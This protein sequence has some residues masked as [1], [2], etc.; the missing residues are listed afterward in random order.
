MES[1]LL[2]LKRYAQFDG[3]SSR[4][5]YWMFHLLQTVILIV[6]IG[7]SVAADFA[8]IAVV[9][10]VIGVLFFGVILACF[11]PNLAVTIRRLHDTDKSG[12]FLLVGA[13][14]LVG[15]IVMLVFLVL[16]GSP[17]ENRFGPQPV[18]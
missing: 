8:Y 4:R 15:G 10:T 13:I 9:P 17:G 5:E 3:R 1:M 18:I 11:V 6:L 14:P 16:P 12:W 7:I 2:P